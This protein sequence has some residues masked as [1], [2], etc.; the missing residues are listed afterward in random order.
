M[1]P[2]PGDGKTL[3]KRMRASAE[4]ET[5][6]VS[7]LDQTAREVRA[8]EARAPGHQDRRLHR[9]RSQ[10]SQE[11]TFLEVPRLIGGRRPESESRLPAEGVFGAPR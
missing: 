11:A 7:L 10:S 1:G 2:V 8:E 9:R 5:D 4:E 6:R 3:E